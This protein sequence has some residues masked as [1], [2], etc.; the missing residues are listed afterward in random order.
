MNAKVKNVYKKC[1]VNFGVIILMFAIIY[2]MNLLTPLL[3]DDYCYTYIGGMT[4]EKVTTVGDLFR[5]A[6]FLWEN[7]SGRV[8]YLFVAQLFLLI[9]KNW[10]NIFNAVVY[11]S[12]T[13]LICVH[14][15]GIQRKKT[16]LFILSNVILWLFTPRF[17]Q[18]MLW[19]TGAANYLWP[20]FFILLFLLPYRLVLLNEFTE[21]KYKKT[22]L[23][24]MFLLGFMGGAGIENASGACVL[25]CL[26]L[27]IYYKFVQKK[28]ILNW[29][30][31]GGLGNLS[32]FLFLILAPGN[33]ARAEL[34]EDTR[35]KIYVISERFVYATNM[36]KSA[37]GNY[38]IV[39]VFVGIP[40]LLFLWNKKK[41]AFLIG[42]YLLTALACNYAMILSPTYPPRSFLGTTCFM[43]IG[44]IFGI[45]CIFNNYIERLNLLIPA[46]GIAL[47]LLEFIPAIWD[48]YNV[49]L[50]SAQ[51]EEYILN[52]IE[53]GHY[54]IS[55]YPIVSYNKYNGIYDLED[56]SED[57]NHYINATIAKYYDLDVVRKAE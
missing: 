13:Y 37:L 42:I 29:M 45:Y 32:G 1:K 2:I 39:L 3:A 53:N 35:N 44:I 51:R 24:V 56:V 14:A 25:L 50:K 22:F 18:N 23:V 49:N 55:L 17:G 40:V 20:M 30:K 41:D 38:I 43:A 57:T 10:F 19:L 52:E 16:S 33:Y 31:A 8:I 54:D 28:I 7:W 9:G 11:I 27:I 36:L 46:V 34:I 12:I 21:C 15:V 47:L 5:S 48:I 4:A 26:L 6:R